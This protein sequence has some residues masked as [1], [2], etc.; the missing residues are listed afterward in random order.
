MAFAVQEIINCKDTNKYEF[1]NRKMRFQIKH[2]LWTK[3]VD[4][5]IDMIEF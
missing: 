1:Y 4:E 2:K 5:T 3:T